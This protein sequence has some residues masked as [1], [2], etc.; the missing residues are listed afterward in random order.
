MRRYIQIRFP[1][2]AY[3]NLLIKRAKIEEDLKQMRGGNK[4]Y[5]LPLTKALIAITDNPVTIGPEYLEKLMREGR[6]RR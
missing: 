4:N 5:K 2:E 3:D 6:H 1:S